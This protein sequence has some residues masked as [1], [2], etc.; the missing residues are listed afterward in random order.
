[1]KTTA[2]TLLPPALMWW[3]AVEVLSV[4]VWLDTQEMESRV[5]VATIHVHYIGQGMESLVQ[6]A[7]IYI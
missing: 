5:Q 2:M 4:C 1:M 3:E 7:T 6:V